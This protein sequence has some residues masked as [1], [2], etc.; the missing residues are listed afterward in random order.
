MNLAGLSLPLL[1]DIENKKKEI[2]NART[3]MYKDD[4]IEAV[5]VFALLPCLY[6]CLLLC[7]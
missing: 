6:F 5:I 4:D 7:Q 2:E 3:Y 1:N